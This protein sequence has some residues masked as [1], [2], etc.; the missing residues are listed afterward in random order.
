MPAQLLSVGG[1]LFFQARDQPVSRPVEL[2]GR[3]ATVR[4]FLPL[5]MRTFSFS[6]GATPDGAP[7]LAAMGKLGELLAAKPSKMSATS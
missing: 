7:V 2:A 6:F 5:M 3:L 1:A 4:P